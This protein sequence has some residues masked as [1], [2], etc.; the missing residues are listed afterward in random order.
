VKRSLSL[1]SEAGDYIGACFLIAHDLG[2]TASHCVNKPE[3]STIYVVAHVPGDGRISLPAKPRF[4]GELDL[5]I[6]EIDDP[7]LLFMS[8]VADYVPSVLERVEW[9]FRSQNPTVSGLDGVV[10]DPSKLRQMHTGVLLESL[11]LRVQTEFPRYRGYS[12]GP[13]EVARDAASMSWGVAGLLLEELLEDDSDDARASN[14]LY[15]ATL[16]AISNADV[17]KGTIL[18]GL[19]LSER[20]SARHST[21]QSDSDL[22]IDENAILQ[23]R[24]A[25]WAGLG[26]MTAEEHDRFS[27]L[28][29]AP[30]EV[31]QGR[32]VC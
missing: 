18:E 30:T 12:G 22:R 32:D 24:F 5:A 20:A 25:L 6:I 4:D 3:Y 2:L 21:R 31:L 16:H 26:L 13:V 10:Q 28:A 15:A 11:E 1:E 29:K 9:R 23:K 8:F 19:I 27:N 7:D 17:L 14:I